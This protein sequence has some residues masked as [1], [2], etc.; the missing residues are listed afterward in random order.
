ME[1]QYD[2]RGVDDS[3]DGPVYVQSA[4]TFAPWPVITNDQPDFVSMYNWGLIPYWMKDEEKALKFRSST[5]NARIETVSEKPSFRKAVRTGRCLVLVDGFYEFRE[6]NRN[7]YPYFI[8]LKGAEPFAMAGIFDRWTNPSTGDIINGFS[9][10]TTR[11]N[12][13]MEKIHNRKKR[14]PVILNPQR[15][16]EWLNHK[17]EPE[18]LMDPFPE[19]LMEAWTVSRILTQRH[20]TEDLSKAVQPYVY[21]ELQDIQTSSSPSS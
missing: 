18:I 13:L 4:F 10:L 7:K 15:Q 9:I 3:F 20:N 1:K 21:P 16:K 14:M 6:V 17:V 12:S 19:N 8:Q 5:V 2:T 11:A